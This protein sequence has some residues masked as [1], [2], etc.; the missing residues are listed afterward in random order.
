MVV[1]P[2]IVLLF[3]FQSLRTQALLL[4]QHLL[5]EQ[6]GTARFHLQELMTKFDEFKQAV[7]TGSERFIL[8][9]EAAKTLLERE[10]PFKRDVLQRQEQLR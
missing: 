2:E 1:R 6:I 4:Y 10:P 8:C 5:M 7:K 3:L 9:E